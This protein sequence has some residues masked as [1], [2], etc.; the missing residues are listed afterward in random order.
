MK[1]DM[2]RAG[3]F[4]LSGLKRRQIQGCFVQ[5]F[6]VE[7]GLNGLRHRLTDRYGNV[8]SEKVGRRQSQ[9]IVAIFTRLKDRQVALAKHEE[10]SMR[11]DATRCLHRLLLTCFK[12]RAMT[13]DAVG[14]FMRHVR[15]FLVW[16]PSIHGISQRSLS[17]R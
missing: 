11:L 17:H 7:C 10:D 1:T 9:P 3:V 16:Q 4:L 13:F 8:F 12:R 15:L 6:A 2:E 5:S 14:M